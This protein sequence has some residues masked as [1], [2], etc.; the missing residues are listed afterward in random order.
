MKK[1]ISFLLVLSILFSL[2]GC[3]T[4]SVK[5]P[6]NFYYLRSESQFSDADGIIAPE[7]REMK[8]LRG[9]LDSILELYMRG[10]ESSN[11]ESPFPRDTKILEWKIIGSSLHL[12]FSD[13]FA[14]LSG[15]ELTLACACI[16]KTCIELLDVE[17]VRIRANGSL[18]NGSTYIIMNASNLNL[19]DDSLD[20]LRTD[21]TVYYTDAR[22]RY[23]IG[24]TVSVNLTHHDNTI[25]YLVS[26]LL[27]APEGMGL[28]SPLPQGTKLLSSRV[29]DGLCSLDFSGEFD[30]N[31]FPQSHAQRTTLLSLVN[32]LTQLENVDRVE[33]F[34]EGNLMAR[35]QE[36]TIS[37]ALVYDESIIGPVRTGMNEFDA[38]LYLANG[39][40]LYLA[41]VPV[42][43]RSTAG[44]TQAEQVVSQILSYHN[45]NGFYS[46]V[47]DGTVLN[48][49]EITEGLCT[50]D[51]SSDFVENTEHL[52]LSVHSIIASVCALEGIDQALIT[53]DGSRPEGEFGDLF[54]PTTPSSNWYL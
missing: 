37:K 7:I 49:L 19:A 3:N 15:V 12:N 22:R 11:L 14:Q 38:T 30:Q 25:S 13:L 35:Y 26:Q 33:F 47:P 51:L 5:D 20:K 34:L 44:I 31:A 54:L 39:S 32:T 16:T 23:L 24:H 17:T 18:L 46:T 9:N 1:Q 52:L 27:T 42:R 4:D 36:L 45:E 28:V 50:I 48:S 40:E 2:F 21:L 10:P 53:V 6:G 29:S 8:D 43:I 41:A